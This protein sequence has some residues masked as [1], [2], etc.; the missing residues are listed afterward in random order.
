MKHR[1]K[2]VFDFGDIIYINA[3]TRAEAIEKYHSLTGMPKDT[4]KKHCLITNEGE[5]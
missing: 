2:L 5:A 1:Y 4:I 3:R